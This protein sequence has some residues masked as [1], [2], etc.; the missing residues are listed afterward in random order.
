VSNRYVAPDFRVDIDGTSLQAEVSRHILDIS[1]DQEPGTLDHFSLT[2]ANPYPAMRWTHTRDA[3]LFQAGNAVTIHMGYVDQLQPLFTGEIT[4]ISPD[5][6][7]S[8]TPTISVEGYSYLHR[9]KGETTTRT[10]QDVTDKQIAEIIARDL[11]LTLEAED[12]GTKHPYIIQYNQ[13]NLAFLLE[14]AQKIRFEMLVDGQTLI[15]R[16]ANNDASKVYTL[17][18]GSTLKSFSVTM[19]TLEPR[20]DVQV[21]GYDP[22]TKQEIIG[23]AGRGAENSSMGGTRTGAEVTA[24]ALEQNRQTVCVDMPVASQQEADQLAQAIYNEH[25]LDF[26]TGT[27]SA[28]GLPQLRAGTVLELTG[29][30]P[31]FS[32]LYYLSQTTHSLND[33]GYQTR[34]SVKRNALS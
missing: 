2:L 29:L 21:R 31:R 32:G 9:L 17:H 22:M 18:W 3:D 23:R 7:E 13:T 4:R 1:V 25:L 11:G 15:F 8:G 20:S 14:R 6:P 33:S 24:A 16:K 10:F 30:G 34:F 12:T 5:F 19:N 27:G 28:I 26:I